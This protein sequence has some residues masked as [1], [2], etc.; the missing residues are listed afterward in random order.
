VKPRLKGNSTLVRFADDA[1]I[2]FADFHDAKRVLDVLGKRLAGT[3]SC[4]TPTRRALSISAA[5]DRK[6]T[7]LRKR[8]ARRSPF[9]ASATSQ[10]SHSSNRPNVNHRG[11]S[12]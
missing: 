12:F 7:T 1:V 9:S 10:N 4:F 2:A 8:M 11:V 5:T 3:S 6:G